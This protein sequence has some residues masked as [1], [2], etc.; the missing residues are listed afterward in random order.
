MSKSDGNDLHIDASDYEQ[1]PSTGWR[2]MTV[3]MDAVAGTG[4]CDHPDCGRDG[5]PLLVV[6]EDGVRRHGVRCS[7][8]QK[9]FL[10]VSS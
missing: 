5:E 7:S 2:E 10:E 4:E 1:S 9:H 8:H 3:I 6:D